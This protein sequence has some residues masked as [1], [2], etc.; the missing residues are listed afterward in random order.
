M[1]D[2]EAPHRRRCDFSAVS[3]RERSI[4]SMQGS[5]TPRQTQIAAGAGRSWPPMP[6][7][8]WPWACQVLV[9]EASTTFVEF[10]LVSLEPRRLRGAMVEA[11]TPFSVRVT[12]HVGSSTA[13]PAV[14]AG[15]VDIGAVVTLL[16]GQH[17]RSSWVCLSIG[18]RRVVLT[19]VVSNLGVEAPI[20]RP[21]TVATRNELQRARTTRLCTQE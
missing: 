15:W 10:D 19:G 7:V 4:T 9:V 14:V 8:W 18:D 3:A 5:V 16:A 2:A 1:I 21:E 17:R 13:D 12:G 11:G 6:C 20:E